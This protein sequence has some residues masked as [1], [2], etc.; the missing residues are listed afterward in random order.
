MVGAAF[1]L[2][3][4][5]LF[6]L[7][8]VAVTKGLAPAGVVPGTA[9]QLVGGAVISLV[10]ALALDG[11]EVATTATV[12]G[13]AAF[14]GAGLIHFVGGWAFL[15]ASIARVGAGRAS[16][17]TGITPLV[18]TIG[19]LVA[20]DETIGVTIVA[21]MLAIVAGTYLITTS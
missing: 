14:A 8:N 6:A 12:A 13:V 17:I 3:A 5:I 21:G 15:N 4:A 18:A 2:L 7:S 1:A 19:A 10:A 9:V 20:L 11:P 16:A